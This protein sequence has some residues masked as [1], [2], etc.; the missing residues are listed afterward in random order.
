MLCIVSRCQETSNCMNAQVFESTV[1]VVENN[2]FFVCYASPSFFGLDHL[3]HMCRV[4][5]EIE[6]IN[7]PA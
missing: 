5:L 1:A 3:N 4:F 7:G 6:E 2:F